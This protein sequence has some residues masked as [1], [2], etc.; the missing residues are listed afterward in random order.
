MI[1]QSLYRVL[2]K[3]LIK[4]LDTREVLLSNCIT[5]EQN[6][7]AKPYVLVIH[8]PSGRGFYLNRNYR[9]IIDVMCCRDPKSPVEVEC[10]HLCACSNMPEWAMAEKSHEFTTFWLFKE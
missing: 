6:T 10:N 7:F 5:G 3:L 4:Y 2:C 9:H 8:R 1:S